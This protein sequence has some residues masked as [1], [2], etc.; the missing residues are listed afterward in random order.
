MDTILA[1]AC[2]RN[3]CDLPVC[4]V[5]PFPAQSRLYGGTSVRSRYVCLASCFGTTDRWRLGNGKYN[6]DGIM[7][8]P[9]SQ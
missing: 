4:L 6:M 3:G 9:R 5:C 7:L 2:S 8:F 1:Q